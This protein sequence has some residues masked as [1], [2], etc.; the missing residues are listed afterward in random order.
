MDATEDRI[1]SLRVMRGGFHRQDFRLNGF[2][3]F[4]RLLN[5]YTDQ[6]VIYHGRI[7]QLVSTGIA[8]TP[9]RQF[10]TLSTPNTSFNLKMVNNH[11]TV[12]VHSTTRKPHCLRLHS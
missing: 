1:H 7:L 2:K 9:A 3:V 10:P 12:S 11:F 4:L 8:E 5:E 6:F